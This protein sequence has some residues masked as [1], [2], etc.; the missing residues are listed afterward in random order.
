MLYEVITSKYAKRLTKLTKGLDSYDGLDLNFAV[1]LTEEVNAFAM[2]DGTVRLY[3]GLLDRM[4]DD[5]VR[6]VVVV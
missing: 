6:Y 2:A 3:S 5:E 1:Y 4:T